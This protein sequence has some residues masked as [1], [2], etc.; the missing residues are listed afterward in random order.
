MKTFIHDFLNKTLAVAAA[1]TAL[2]AAQPAAVAQLQFTSLH[3][4]NGTSGFGT[5]AGVVQGADSAIFSFSN[6][7][8]PT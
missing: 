4:F 5:M 6:L 2:T 7:I 8:R 1:L 3:S